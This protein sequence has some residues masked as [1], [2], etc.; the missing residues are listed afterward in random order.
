MI[1]ILY[2]L[3]LIGTIASASTAE[4]YRVGPDQAYLN[5]GD[6][7][8]ESLAAGDSV[9]I[10]ARPEPYHE[11]WV[12]CARG[13]AENPIVVHG[14]LGPDGQRPVIDGRNAATRDSL[15]Y[16]SEPRGIIKIDGANRPTDVTPAHI[17]V[18]NLHIRSGRPPYS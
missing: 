5:I 1:R 17:T 18:E 7:P 2:L 4:T 10:H 13:T 15:D 6:V 3:V 16:W 9:L 14:V 8:W 11:K 12:I